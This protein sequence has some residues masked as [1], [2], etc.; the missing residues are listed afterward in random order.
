MPY[1]KLIT[2][3]TTGGHDIFITCPAKK[4][5]PRARAQ[6]APRARGAYFCAG[7]VMKISYPPVVQRVI[8]T[9]RSL[10]SAFVI[11][12]QDSILL[13]LLYPNFQD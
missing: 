6:G 13:Y 5:A 1:G 3:F 12:C 9:L 10:I 2:R 8:T 7:Q 4:H 11:R